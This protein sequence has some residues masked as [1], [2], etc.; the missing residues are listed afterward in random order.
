MRLVSILRHIAIL[1]LVLLALAGFSQP[2][3]SNGP[4]SSPPRAHALVNARIIVAP[5]EII[6]RG[7]VVI[8]DGVITDVGA[9]AAVPADAR[10]W[11][12]DGKTIH[13][14]FIDLSVP[15]ASPRELPASPGRHWSNKVRPELRADQLGGV[16]SGVAGS[17]REMGFTAA[18]A[19]PDFGI[20][21][22]SGALVSLGTGEGR[23]TGSVYHADGPQVVYFEQGGW[24]SNEYPGSLIG[25][26]ALVRQTL[27]D[28]QWHAQCMEV[29]AAN[30]AGLEPPVPAQSLEAL[31]DVV[32]GEAQ[33]RRRPLMLNTYDELDLFRAAR[34]REEFGL[35]LIV[36][37]SGMEFRWLDEVVE[38]GLPIVLPL[39]FPD[40]PDV[41]NLEDAQAVTLRDLMA[42][43]QAPTNPRRLIEAGATVALTTD[44]IG[45][46]S[47]FFN[48]L[49]TAMK[50]GLT[51]E[52]ALAA[53][54][55]TPAELAGVA[56]RM[57]R[58][59][60]GYVANL[61]LLGVAEDKELDSIFSEHREVDSVWIDG[62]RFEIDSPPIVDP[63]GSWTL[64]LDNAEDLTIE[65]SGSADRPKVVLTRPAADE[66]ADEADAPADDQEQPAEAAEDDAEE[67][68]EPK[69]DRFDAKAVSV[70]VDRLGFALP[71]KAFGR[72][73]WDRYSAVITG[74][75]MTGSA[76]TEAGET[77]TW[78]ATR[79][80]DE[81]DADDETADD[82]EGDDEDSDD[83]DEADDEYERA[84]EAYPKPLGAFGR[85]EPLQRP[86]AVIVRNATI[87][88]GTD[89]G[90][91][92]NADLLIR[93][94]TIAAV[95][96][97]LA[98]PAG[99]LEIDATGKHIT[100]GLID[101]H[102]HTGIDR[103]SVNEGTQAI[104]SETRIRDVI[105][106]DDMNW[107]RQLAGGLVAANQLHGSANPIGGQNSVVKIRW[108]EP[109]S[110]FPVEGAIEGI[111]F[112]LGENVKQANWGENYTSRYP[113]T[114][115]GVEQVFRYAFSAARDYRA[116]FARYN[117]LGPAE[118]QRAYPPRR[119]L[120]L[121]ALAEILE[122]SRLVH[123]HSYRQDEILMLIRVADDFGFTIGTFQH[124]LEGF[125]V[126]AEMAEHGVGG[127]SFSDWWAY[128]FEVYDAIPHNGALM[129]DVGVLV[130]F[131][132][133]SNDHARRMNLEAAR[134]VRYGGATP[135]E[136]LNYVALNPAKQLRIDDRTGSIEVGK[137]ADFVIWSG[138][139]LSGF[140][141]C[142][143]TWI[144]GKPY[145]TLEEDAK[146]REYA[147]SERQRLMKKILR[148]AL[149]D[150][151][152]ERERGGRGE[153][154]QR[155]EGD[156]GDP[157][158]TDEMRRRLEVYLMGSGIPD[159][160]ETDD[161]FT[162]PGE[163]GCNILPHMLTGE[164]AH[165]HTEHDH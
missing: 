17:L 11:D 91:L 45:N 88:T 115:M 57:G 70:R 154:P 35:T 44:V 108:G 143:Q 101:C 97:N 51:E 59:A 21:R 80:P 18:M 16:E 84:P 54:T 13:A 2:Q 139:P 52:Q 3:P 77:F 157:P 137:D 20:F 67:D 7:V 121:D 141:K 79:Q 146:M 116:D 160:S 81:D 37:G 68:A 78:S 61:V 75:A 117:A 63:R 69:R 55:T 87:W 86:D 131:N 56:D 28:A 104:T 164:H 136:A 99:A 9:D 150:P 119:D 85:L 72:T 8:R 122:G 62:E 162:G 46:R 32:V 156:E 134:G 95:G 165:S 15:F 124:I 153:R 135:E 148:L 105:D 60:P 129:E 40:R 107:Y 130:S 39:T 89:D 5:G 41:E 53:L 92:E 65:I 161:D 14:G 4:P 30:P 49:R 126:A 90:I 128:K 144:D 34:L 140:T 48:H 112:A 142:E 138:P 96:E 64:T 23:Y 73:G 47:D 25:A 120:E 155:G 145:F 71:G 151:D 132:S 149:S 24:G 36:R 125:K 43:E 102:S 74:Q 82:A 1:S 27:Y 12:A 127:S 19:V 103:W 26:I 10:V 42:W 123:C 83:E 50:E 163:C 106:A 100:A 152:K 94:G 118:A 6:E 33:G 22:G 159:P 158:M 93:D 110:A 29:Y 31:R 147:A 98:A 38:T 113:Q 114:R 76:L 109:A 58:V 111:K 66:E 133:D